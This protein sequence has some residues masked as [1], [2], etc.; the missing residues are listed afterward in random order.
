MV[1]A[2]YRCCCVSWGAAATRVAPSSMAVERRTVATVTEAA[3]NG[4][5]TAAVPSESWGAQVRRQKRAAVT[6]RAETTNGHGAIAVPFYLSGS[7]RGKRAAPKFNG[8]SW[9][10]RRQTAAARWRS[11]RNVLGGGGQV[12]Q[13]QRAAVTARVG[14][15][16]NSGAVAVPSETLEVRKVSSRSSNLQVTERQR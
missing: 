11:C 9:R 4:S 8:G 14:T 16:N 3:A 2:Q 1:V 15:K 10:Q 12:R 5:G 13:Q 6:A 7:G